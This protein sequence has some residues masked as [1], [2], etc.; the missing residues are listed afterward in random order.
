[1]KT[2]IVIIIIAIIIAITIISIKEIRLIKKWNKGKKQIIT[3]YNCKCEIENYDTY[4][5]INYYIC[6]KC[7]LS[8]PYDLIESE[9]L[10]NYDETEV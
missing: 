3:C 7:G 6:E 10:D 8:Y 9:L 2:L 4:L 1:M 5:G